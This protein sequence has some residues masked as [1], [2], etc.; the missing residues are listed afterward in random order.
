MG[1]RHA[2]V[3]GFPGFIARRLVRKL[4]S[5]DDDVVL[6]LIVEPTQLDAA[7]KELAT[8]ATALGERT[9]IDERVRILSG[10][11]TWMDLGLSG[12]EFRTIVGS[13]T[14][15]YHLAAIHAVGGDKDHMSAVNVQGTANVLEVA[16]A[17]KKLERFVHFS[18]A[19]V[20]GDRVGVILEEE[21]D[22]GQGFH[23]AYESTKHKAEQLVRRETERLPITIVRPAG[24]VGDSRTGEIDRFDSV[25]H[26]GML[27]AASPVAIT[28]PLPGPGH[29]PLNLVPVD[30][31]VD[32]V[33]AI[34]A[35]PATIGRTFHVVDPNPLSSRSVYDAIAAR[36]G[37]KLPRYNVSP[38]LTKVLLRIPGLERFAA[39]SH[40]A[41]DYL[42]HMAFYNSR[43]TM[44]A[45]DGTGIRCPQFEDY[46]DNLMRYVREYF[47]RVDRE[48]GA[49]RPAEHT[50]GSG[51]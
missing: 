31:V 13:A 24:V 49:H 48:S 3:T 21:L 34:A 38:N 29:A 12:P 15:V 27:L 4:V 17:M 39:V 1:D 16:R 20:S 42:N 9:R 10:D 6:T 19:Y 36:T 43:N 14:E 22:A 5:A 41:I 18:S 2:L 26:I 47:E 35:S 7:K 25:Y 46:V 51:I 33:H 37:R 32:A 40:Q 30:Y 28:I 23:N 50:E 44:E 11:I 45:L 8:L